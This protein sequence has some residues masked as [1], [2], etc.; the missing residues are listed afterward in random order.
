MNYTD[1]KFHYDMNDLIWK[2]SEAWS[3]IFTNVLKVKVALLYNKDKRHVKAKEIDIHKIIL[4]VVN[5]T[6]PV[7]DKY[8]TR[9]KGYSKYGM[10]DVNDPTYDD[11]LIQS[12]D[13][14]RI[15]CPFD[16][17]FDEIEVR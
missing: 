4:D 17:L 11:T 12:I 2:H 3:E 13:Y 10:F 1:G 5:D 8:L 14:T 15:F 9:I 16:G 7:F 6:I